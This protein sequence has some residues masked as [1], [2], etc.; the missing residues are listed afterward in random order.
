MYAT[1]DRHYESGLFKVKL[2]S[3]QFFDNVTSANKINGYPYDASWGTANAS[4]GHQYS[5]KQVKDRYFIFRYSG[6]DRYPF[7]LFMYEKNDKP[8]VA[9]TSKNLPDKSLVGTADN[10]CSTA[11]G[12]KIYE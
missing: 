12:Q 5:E 6:D 10:V 11:N 1:W 8:V 7:A 3:N 9:G 4:R 2:S